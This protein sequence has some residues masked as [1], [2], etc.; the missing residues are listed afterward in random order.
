MGSYDTTSDF[1]TSDI[2]RHG[3]L[4]NEFNKKYFEFN[5]KFHKEVFEP[6][7]N[8]CEKE[9]YRIMESMRT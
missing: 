2:E 1:S 4:K 5:R 3:T 8:Y 9:I 7:G 6:N